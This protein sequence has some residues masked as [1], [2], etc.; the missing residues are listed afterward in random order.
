MIE[1]GPEMIVYGPSI[2]RTRLELIAFVLEV[3]I[4]A[5]EIIVS[6]P[7]IIIFGTA[8]MKRR[9]TSTAG[10]DEGIVQFQN[11]PKALPVQLQRYLQLAWIERCCR[12]AR[13]SVKRVDIGNIKSIHKIENV[14]N[15]VECYALGQPYPP[16]NAEIGKDCCGTSSS[17]SS[18]I[19]GH[20]VIDKTCCLKKSGWRILRRDGF[21]TARVRRRPRRDDIRPVRVGTEV[22]V[23]IGSGE[24]RKWASGTEFDD[25]RYSP[26]T[27]K[28]TCCIARVHLA[29]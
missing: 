11:L 12:R 16:A 10:R 7:Q 17:I 3:I 20:S 2:T 1:S 22:E 21:V 18:E 6:C 29:G 5:P 14:E 19:A 28:L 25:R 23:R 27:E 24:D 13:L 9:S 26:I 4:D 8:I 15:A